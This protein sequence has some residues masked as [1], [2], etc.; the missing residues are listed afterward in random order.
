MPT[1]MKTIY[2]YANGAK[3]DV[4]IDY[5]HKNFDNCHSQILEFR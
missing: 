5:L 1:R 4:V 3:V 2:F